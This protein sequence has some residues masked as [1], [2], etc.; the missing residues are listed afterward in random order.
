MVY[1]IGDSKALMGACFI[2]YL[3]Y[4]VFYSIDAIKLEESENSNKEADDPNVNRAKEASR[5]K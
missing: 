4:I 1:E 3:V 5:R 2:H